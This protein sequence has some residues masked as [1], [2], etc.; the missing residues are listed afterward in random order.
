[1]N[2]YTVIKGKVFFKNGEKT[3]NFKK[4]TTATGLCL[5]I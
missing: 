4:T 3:T 2:I 5:K 1:M